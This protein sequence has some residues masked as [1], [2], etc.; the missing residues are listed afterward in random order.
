MNGR[1]DLEM[2]LTANVHREAGSYWA[3]VSE[4]PGCF[5]AGE[6]LDELFESLQEGIQLYLAEGPGPGQAVSRD[7]LRI[8]S[9]VLTDS[10]A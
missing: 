10:P 4:L 1:G 3:E 7:S 8:R 5:G 2:E 9:A 6:T